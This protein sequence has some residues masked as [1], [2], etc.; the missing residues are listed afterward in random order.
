MELET[1]DSICFKIDQFFNVDLKSK[2]RDIKHVRARSI[3]YKVC[4]DYFGPITYRSIGASVNRDH[5]TVIHSYKNFDDNIKYDIGLKDMYLRITD[6]NYLLNNETII[7]NLKKDKE[8]LN[9][10]LDKLKRSGLS[11]LKNPIINKLND[12]LSSLNEEDALSLT[13]KLDALYNINL[14]LYKNGN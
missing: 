7:E 6:N 9:E 5:S 8:K 12:M 14:K 11:V 2:K 10:E 13:I 1:F 4:F 3:Y